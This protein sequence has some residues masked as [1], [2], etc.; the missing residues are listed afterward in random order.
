VKT[1]LRVLT[2]AVFLLIASTAPSFADGN[3][4]PICN[5]G[6]CSLVTMN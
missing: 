4:F 2:V 6:V 1:I 5:K 3:P